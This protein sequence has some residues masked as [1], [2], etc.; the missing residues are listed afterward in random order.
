VTIESEL[1]KGT[2]VTLYLPRGHKI[3]DTVQDAP[4]PESASGGTVLLVED[5]P[6]V[7]EV[8]ISMAGGARLPSADGW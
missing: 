3:S 5:N 8:S 6:D 2:M 7:A 1:G 4:E